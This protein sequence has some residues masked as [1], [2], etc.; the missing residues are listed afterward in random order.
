MEGG[1]E[2][3]RK[4]DG[5][6]GMRGDGGQGRVGEVEAIK[7]KRCIASVMFETNRA[8]ATITTTI[9]ENH[10]QQEHRRQHDLYSHLVGASLPRLQC[11]PTRA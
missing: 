10:H 9:A 5:D 7:R 3:G 11:S 2:G 8:N 6:G 1:R 4:E